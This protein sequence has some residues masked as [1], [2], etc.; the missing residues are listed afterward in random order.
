MTARIPPQTDPPLLPPACS[1]PRPLA[2][3]DEDHDP[4]CLP[5]LPP[6]AHLGIP[7]HRFRVGI[8]KD[9]TTA[10]F[11]LAATATPSSPRTP[12]DP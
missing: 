9:S 11:T 1:C 2:Y 4:R 8:T 5:L 6:R 7:E 3:L 10:V 12:H